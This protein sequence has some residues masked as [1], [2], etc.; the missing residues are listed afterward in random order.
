MRSTSTWLESSSSWRGSSTKP[1]NVAS[2]VRT[3]VARRAASMPFPE[4]SPTA[5]TV[6]SSSGPGATR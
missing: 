5:S 1:A 4:T 3:K 6:E 2:D